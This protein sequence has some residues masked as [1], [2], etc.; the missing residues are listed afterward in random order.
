M[1]VFK[2]RINTMNNEDAEAV[3][4]LSK[5]ILKYINRAVKEKITGD[6]TFKSVVREVEGDKYCISCMDGTA[7]KVKCCIPNVKLRVGQAVYVKMMQGK[8]RDMHICGVV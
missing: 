8:I 5:E 3:E 2:E 6:I 7:R 4:T 1:A